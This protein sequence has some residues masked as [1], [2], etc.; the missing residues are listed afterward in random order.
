MTL[1]V[2]VNTPELSLLMADARLTSF[3]PRLGLVYN[4]C[5][6]K[7]FRVSH[8]TLFGF[9][10]SVFAAADLMNTLPALYEHIGD[11]AYHRTFSIQQLILK[12]TLQGGGMADAM[13][14]PDGTLPAA[15]LVFTGRAH[16]S[17]P[18]FQTLH[19]SLPTGRVSLLT[20]HGI[21]TLGSGKAFFAPIAAALSDSL[22]QFRNAAT[23]SDDP[24]HYLA[25]Q[26]SSFVSATLL[27]RA[28][29]PARG[30][31]QI[32][33][34]VGLLLHGMYV[35]SDRVTPLRVLAHSV[36]GHAYVSSRQLFP[37]GF[38]VVYVDERFRVHAGSDEYVV[39]RLP[40]E[41]IAGKRLQRS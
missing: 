7:V 5:C 34:S 20:Q 39:L 22:E 30:G 6:Q 33:P 40:S 12:Y 31:E 19:F 2:A 15:D 8:S 4:D 9:A 24:P 27:A 3:D 36:R 13:R 10:G 23:Q 14:L 32:P 26:I 38:E 1:I 18:I 35:D 41:I 28:S 17:Q 25:W 11:E 16:P 37:D 29:S 21:T